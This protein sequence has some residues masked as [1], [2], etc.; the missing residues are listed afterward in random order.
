M[1]TTP[2]TQRKINHAGGLCPKCQGNVMLRDEV[3]TCIQC[4][5]IFE[6]RLRS[7][8]TAVSERNYHTE[9]KPEPATATA[10]APSQ[11]KPN[12][13]EPP[14]LSTK[15]HQNPPDTAVMTPP[16]KTLPCATQAHPLD[17]QEVPQAQESPPS[18]PDQELAHREETAQNI[19]N[20]GPINLAPAENQEAT[21]APAEQT[22]ESGQK[23]LPYGMTSE[24]AATAFKTERSTLEWIIDQRWP[25][26]VPCPNCA[27]KNVRLTL[28]TPPVRYH[29]NDCQ[30][31]FSLLKDSQLART[32]T[33]IN[34]WMLTS[35]AILTNADEPENAI[36]TRFGVAWITER[37]IRE[38]TL[39]STKAGLKVYDDHS[40]QRR[41]DAQ[42]P[43]T[44]PA[45]TYDPAPRR[46]DPLHQ[47]QRADAPE[48][49][50]KEPQD[51]DMQHQETEYRHQAP[52]P[53]PDLEQTVIPD[54]PA[55]IAQA[56]QPKRTDPDAEPDA[57]AEAEAHDP[58]SHEVQPGT[59]AEPQQPADH[60]KDSKPPDQQVQEQMQPAQPQPEAPLTIQALL[61]RI[62]THRDTLEDR[63]N[64]LND[65]LVQVRAQKRTAQEHHDTVSLALIVQ[66][67]WET[68]P[69]STDRQAQAQ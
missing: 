22:Q 30:G 34:R 27:S 17:S 35:H 66:Q 58:A 44:N 45:P 54:A 15:P 7:L 10:H 24:E 5:A 51:Q 56:E 55:P 26:G 3:L 21:T 57:D 19:H 50:H 36:A 63:E 60:G 43:R 53:A 4:S 61:D 42:E 9:P 1:T 39:A 25:G 13:Q 16:V 32:R 18:S 12:K 33:P 47:A 14:M 37:K 29:C 41:H 46:L 8:P 23:E 40:T 6:Y 64:Q 28:I 69:P 2:T 62:T 20:P 59:P 48:N 49:G 11:I 31:R 65:E 67:E 68:S 38:Q 52:E